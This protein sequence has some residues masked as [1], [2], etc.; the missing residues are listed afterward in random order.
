M[1]VAMVTYADIYH[2]FLSLIFALFMSEFSHLQVTDDCYSETLILPDRDE[3][4]SRGFAI[5]M[6]WNPLL[7]LLDEPFHYPQLYKNTFI[8][9]YILIYDDNSYT[10][11]KILFKN[12]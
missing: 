12:R 3:K 9:A 5:I 6:V 7:L 1:K 4:K 8:D 10:V 2:Y 11:L